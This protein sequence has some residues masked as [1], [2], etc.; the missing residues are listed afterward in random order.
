MANR[1]RKNHV[2]FRCTDDELAKIEEKMAETGLG[3]TDLFLRLLDEKN[4]VIVHDL[5]PL[6][7]E[8]KRQGANLNQILRY[9][10]NDKRYLPHLDDAV[11]NCDEIYKKLFEF[12]KEIK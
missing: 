9:T 7:L 1:K 10:H 3:Q 6:L 11:K 5:K 12:W 8:L 4:I 2:G